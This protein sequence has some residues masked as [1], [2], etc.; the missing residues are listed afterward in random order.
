MVMGCSTPFFASNLNR[1]FTENLQSNVFQHH[2]DGH[3]ISGGD[4]RAILLVHLST[5]A[6]SRCHGSGSGTR[7]YLTF[8]YC[9]PCTK[10]TDNQEIL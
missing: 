5:F 9:F 7:L 10:V 2:S 4:S 1:V 8:S 3:V 6:V